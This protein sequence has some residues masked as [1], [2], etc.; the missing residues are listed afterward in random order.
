MTGCD[1][2]GHTESDW[3]S[4]D[5]VLVLGGVCELYKESGRL[6]AIKRVNINTTLY[7]MGS[8]QSFGDESCPQRH[9][10]VDIEFSSQFLNRPCDSKTEPALCSAISLINTTNLSFEITAEFTGSVY[11][12]PSDKNY[13]VD[14]MRFVFVLD[15]MKNLTKAR[16]V[17]AEKP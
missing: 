10:L 8:V 6:H 4:P 16:V 17:E 11:A 3:R 9:S 1:T 7:R 5:E 12:V 2:T 15:G 13:S 14:G